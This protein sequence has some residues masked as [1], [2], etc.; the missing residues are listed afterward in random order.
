MAN[1]R[2]LADEFS[3]LEEEFK[4]IL[5]QLEGTADPSER[6]LLLEDVKMLIQLAHRLVKEHD[7]SVR[8]LLREA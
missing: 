7:K 2:R 6:R 8:K 4:A 1:T 5:A 3:R